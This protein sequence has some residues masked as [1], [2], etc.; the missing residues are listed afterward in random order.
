MSDRTATNGNGRFSLRQSW[1]RI[2]FLM[3]REFQA[4]W[5][6]KRSRTVLIVPPLLQLFLFT[7][8]ATFDVN[9]VALAVYN[10]DMGL[11]GREFVA[12]LTGSNAFTDVKRL[13]SAQEIAPLI[14]ARAAMMVLR[15]P[16]TFSRDLA[17]GRTARAQLI[18]DG[19]ESNS[20][21]VASGY[22][23]QIAREFSR[24]RR[25]TMGGAAEPP[26]VVTR[27][28]F[29]ANL[30]SKWFIVPGL[31]ATLTMIIATVI[32]ALSIA[33]ERELGTFEQLLV[34]PLRPL[35]IL[36]GKIAPAA[37]LGM[38]EGLALGALGVLFFGVP[39]RGDL[40]MLVAALAVFLL[41]V[42]S[43][44]LMISALTSTQQQAQ[45]AAFCFIMPAVILSGFTTPIHNMPQA[46]QLLTYLNPLRY[47]LTINRGIF[48][49]DMPVAVVLDNMWPMAVIGVA[50]AAG[51]TWLFSRRLE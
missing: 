45:I 19:R 33:R 46:I 34:T 11:S 37:I 29:N 20:A 43:F 7:Y 24:D 50:A 31:V 10:E 44:G 25:R 47:I 3:V 14:D 16:P 17:A 4:I 30:D 39:L 18:V 35:E 23:N 27:A 22:V 1:A 26:V 42:T 8:A 41:S 9:N 36:A 32:T 48:L 12:R 6:D 21:L 51:A 40:F 2:A 5:R 13:T 49:Q 28:W 15:I 38:A